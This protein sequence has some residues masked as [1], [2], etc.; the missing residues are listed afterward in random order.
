MPITLTD[1]SSSFPP[2]Y[3]TGPNSFLRYFRRRPT[4][5]TDQKTLKNMRILTGLE[6]HFVVIYANVVTE[7]ET[8][9][10]SRS[11]NDNILGGTTWKEHIWKTR[12]DGS[13]GY[14]QDH[15]QHRRRPIGGS[16]SIV[17]IA[18]CSTSIR[19][20]STR[21]NPSWPTATASFLSKGHGGP[22]LYATLALKGYFPRE[23]LLTLN[24]FEYQPARV[25]PTKQTVGIDMTTS[26]LGQ[27]FRRRRYGHRRGTRSFAVS[28][29]RHDR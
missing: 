28:H 10:S 13:Q 24:R 16:M 11:R 17:D 5:S 8:L 12:P 20:I 7:L 23:D 14:N 21:N 25:T 15:R 26:S 6:P 3:S 4:E 19:C 2:K 22:A 18:P 9:P 29:L 1:S 27:V